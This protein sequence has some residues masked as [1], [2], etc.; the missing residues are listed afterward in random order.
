LEGIF[1]EAVMAHLNYYYSTSADMKKIKG[2][3]CH[4]SWL[5]EG[6]SKHGSPM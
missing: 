6:N 2:N 1:E 5:M 4:D 3:F